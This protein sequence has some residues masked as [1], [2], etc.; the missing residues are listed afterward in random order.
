MSPLLVA[1]T[2]SQ[3]ASQPVSQSGSQAVR[4]SASQPVRQS[5]SQSVT[6]GRRPG[7]WA[8]RQ[9]TGRAGQVDTQVPKW[10]AGRTTSRQP[11]R[12]FCAGSA[13]LHPEHWRGQDAAP[14]RARH[15]CRSKDP[16]WTPWYLV[17]SRFA[18]GNVS[19]RFDFMRI[20]GFARQRPRPRHVEPGGRLRLRVPG[21]PRVPLPGAPEHDAGPGGLQGL[22]G[23]QQ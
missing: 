8:G 3:P 6:Q 1:K 18:R 12:L 21:Q 9:A 7:E 5:G 10:Q 11:A 19:I 15:L 14:V 4:Q 17:F 16:T 13:V 2:A 22:R 23:S 20:S